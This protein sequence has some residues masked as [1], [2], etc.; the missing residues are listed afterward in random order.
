MYMSPMNPGASKGMTCYKVFVG[1]GTPF[2]GKQ[3]P[4]SI[5]FADSSLTI[6][7]VE[8]SDPVPWTKPEDIEYSPD[9]PLPRFGNPPGG[10][11]PASCAD[12]QAK[13]IRKGTSEAFIRYLITTQKNGPKPPG[14]F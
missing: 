6:L 1:E 3:P 4:R 10:D 9:K 2:G 8:A 11:F 7:V 14:D 13:M 5:D 12:G